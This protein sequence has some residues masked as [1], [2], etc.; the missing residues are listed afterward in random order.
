LKAVV[1]RDHVVLATGA[2]PDTL[3]EVLQQGQALTETDLARLEPFPPG[4][5]ARVD[6][7]DYLPFYLDNLAARLAESGKTAAAEGTFRQARELAPGNARLRYN[8]GT[9]LLQLERFEDA[10]AELDRAIRL[11]WKDADA[12]VNRGVARFKLGRYS[13]A[14]RDFQRALRLDPQ[15]RRAQDN[16]AML[17]AVSTAPR[18]D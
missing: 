5:P 16:L 1:F 12:F 11:G 17:D 18:P 6:G 8:Y 15:N 7:W 2:E 13:Q 4:G 14:R 3:F 9:F 10:W